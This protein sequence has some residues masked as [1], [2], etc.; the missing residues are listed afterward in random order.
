MDA[1]ETFADI[2]SL[3]KDI[4]KQI[5]KEQGLRRLVLIDLRDYIVGHIAQVNSR[6]NQYD[7]YLGIIKPGKTK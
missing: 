3:L 6:V 4:D 1:I 5:P 7:P 2:E